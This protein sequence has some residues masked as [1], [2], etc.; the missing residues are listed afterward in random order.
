MAPSTEATWK[1]VGGLTFDSISTF[2]D[3]IMA[4]LMGKNRKVSEDVAT[5]FS[6][7]VATAA[8]GMEEI[9][10]AASARAH[11]GF[12]QNQVYTLINSASS[13]PIEIVGL[14]ALESKGEEQDRTTVYGPAIIG[15]AATPKAPAWVGDCLHFETALVPR[16][17]MM[18]VKGPDGKMAKVEEKVFDTVVRA[19]FMRHPDPKTGIHFP[20]KPRVPPEMWPELLKA[21]PG[22]YFEPGLEAGLDHFLEVEDSLLLSSGDR[23]KKWR[24]EMDSKRMGGAGQVTAAGQAKVGQD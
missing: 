13:L 24:E 3:L 7:K 22:G 12:I 15:K 8:G 2:C 20:A 18:D 19:Y 11:Y 10:F 5:P 4:D 23:L 1:E 14:T 16:V 9:K 21:F 17:T 6:E